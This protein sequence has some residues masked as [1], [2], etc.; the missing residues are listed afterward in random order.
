MMA[1][2]GGVVSAVNVA[3]TVF[4]AVAA[5]VHCVPTLVLQ[6]LQPAKVEVAAGVAVSTTA[7]PPMKVAEQLVPQVIPV[8]VLVTIP[9]PVPALTTASATV[10]DPIVKVRAFE[11]PAT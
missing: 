4:V 11:V 3:V 10:D 1:T 6:P 2:V 7:V 5:T 9:E 8:G